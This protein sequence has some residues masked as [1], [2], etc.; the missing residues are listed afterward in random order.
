M[1]GDG[2]PEKVCVACI[3]ELKRMFVFKQRCE[4]SD[5]TLRAYFKKNSCTKTSTESPQTGFCID[6]V[7]TVE[8]TYQINYL[9]EDEKN[10]IKFTN[11]QDKT[12]NVD[13]QDEEMKKG[14]PGPSGQMSQC[15]I[16]LIGF[17]TDAQLQL[18]LLDD[19]ATIQCKE[20]IIDEPCTGVDDG[21]APYD[22]LIFINQNELIIKDEVDDGEQID[23]LELSPAPDSS[24]HFT[25]N[26]LIDAAFKCDICKKKFSKKTFIKRHIMRCHMPSKCY[27]CKL[28]PLSK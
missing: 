17:D 20:E 28:C 8:G 9:D 11:E 13:V 19:H 7:K 15:S 21:C 3:N 25:S 16:C 27:G 26:T 4:E 2:L 18:H 22:N 10:V 23:N 1:K 5:F 24:T 14:N 6:E 12:R